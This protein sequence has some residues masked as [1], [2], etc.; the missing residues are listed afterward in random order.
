MFAGL[1]REDKSNAVLEVNIFYVP[2][3]SVSV[4]FS[5]QFIGLVFVKYSLARLFFF[6]VCWFSML[7]FSMKM[8]EQDRFKK[9]KCYCASGLDS[10]PVYV[11]DNLK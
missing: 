6:N 11:N 1:K 9:K 10:T 4:F 2:L 7:F 3:S 8:C 5:Y